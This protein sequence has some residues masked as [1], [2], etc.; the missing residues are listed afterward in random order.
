MHVLFRCGV[1]RSKAEAQAV[2]G[3]TFAGVGVTDDYAAY[4]NLFNSMF[5]FFEFE[6]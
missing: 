4:K 6:G 3:E 2:L 5:K 1:S